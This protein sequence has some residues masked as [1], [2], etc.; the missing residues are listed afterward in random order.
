MRIV[1]RVATTDGRPASDVKV[2][3]LTVD[4][5]LAE[6]EVQGGKLALSVDEQVPPVWALAFDGQPVLTFPVK[7]RDDLVD[8]GE[9]VTSPDG[10]P[11]AGFHAPDGRVF[12]VPRVLLKLMAQPGDE[13]PSIPET[14]IDFATAVPLRVL[15]GS[16]TQQLAAAA[17]ATDRLKLTGATVTVRGLPSGTGGD[18][19]LS[20]P[21][22]EL[23]RNAN[24]LSELSFA[25]RPDSARLPGKPTA[26]EATTA[27][28]D[29]TGYT[30]D[31]AVRK[32]ATAG[33][34]VSVAS[35]L[36]TE[37]R[38]VGRVVRQ[39]PPGRSPNGSRCAGPDLHR[40]GRRSVVMAI[41]DD[42]LDVLSAPLGDLIASVGRGI[43]DAQRA[44]D[45][46][47]MAALREIYG[48][49]EDLFRELQAIGYRPTWYHIPEAE[50]DIQIALSVTGAETAT[51]GA[52]S[53]STRAKIKLYAAPVDAGYSS[54]YN[55]AVTASSRAEV[56]R[57]AGAAKLGRRGDPGGAVA[58]RPPA[59]RG[60]RAAVA[61]GDRR[62]P[63]RR[64]EQCGRADA[65]ARARHDP[66][67]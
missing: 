3:L 30:R 60:A 62:G 23:A 61:A 21:E 67:S 29:L 31:L 65:D 44:L 58:G 59:R 24:G 27:L 55:F 64:R 7:A 41:D 47:S 34:A 22:T 35:E 4:G 6:G 13:P 36:V 38:A 32:L 18:F 12:G 57:R 54:R 16:S 33:H 48:S 5:S 9:I 11:W 26:P 56:P 10:W 8:L 25:L 2:E 28:P 63:Y 46:A 43:A 17:T 40:Q 51:P 49:N 66:R 15:L 39:T 1:A 45:S 42:L 37:P 19:G 52:G 50:G 14:P 20:F 53:V